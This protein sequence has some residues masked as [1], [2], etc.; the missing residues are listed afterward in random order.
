LSIASIGDV[1]MSHMVSDILDFARAGLEVDAVDDR[2]RRIW[3]QSSTRSSMKSIRSAKDDVIV[4]APP[5][6]RS[7]G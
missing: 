7:M 2:Q 6:G 1:R 3:W 5:S 4:E